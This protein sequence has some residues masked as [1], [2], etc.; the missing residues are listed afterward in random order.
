MAGGNH[1][2]HA[3]IVDPLPATAALTPTIATAIPH[4]KMGR[5]YEEVRNQT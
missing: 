2:E 5:E 4:G 1:A 3:A